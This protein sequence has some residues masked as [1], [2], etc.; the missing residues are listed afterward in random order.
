MYAS[1]LCCKCQVA[2]LPNRKESKE[3][4]SVQ[5]LEISLYYHCRGCCWCDWCRELNPQFCWLFLLFCWLRAKCFWT[6]PVHVC[7]NVHMNVNILKLYLFHEFE[8]GKT[9]CFF[10]SYTNCEIVAF[11]CVCSLP[12]QFIDFMIY[13]SILSGRE[14]QTEIEKNEK[15]FPAC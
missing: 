5:S 13:L 14:N 8:V 7:R 15:D 10:K 4:G 1:H 11:M 2:L 12:L 9:I 3:N 6:V